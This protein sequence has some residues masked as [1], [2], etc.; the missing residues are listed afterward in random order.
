MTVSFISYAWNGSVET[1]MGLIFRPDTL[2]AK[3]MKN[4]K[5]YRAPVM[6]H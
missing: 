5:F 6:H 1:C 3:N 2:L 4:Q